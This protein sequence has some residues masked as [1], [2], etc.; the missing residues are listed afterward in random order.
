MFVQ[1]NENSRAFIFQLNTQC[2]ER[3]SLTVVLKPNSLRWETAKNGLKT[4]R[5]KRYSHTT[6]SRIRLLFSDRNADGVVVSK[7]ARTFRR[8]TPCWCTK[9]KL[10]IRFENIILLFLDRRGSLPVFGHILYAPRHH[11]DR[12]PA[13][14]LLTVD[15]IE[16]TNYSIRS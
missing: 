11:S 14:V 1:I 3:S 8:R 6:S 13:A 4:I 5:H 12:F 9:R 7:S 16:L 2:S 10:K 15:I